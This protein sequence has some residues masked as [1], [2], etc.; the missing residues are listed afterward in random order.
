MADDDLEG[1][2]GY[3]HITAISLKGGQAAN[4]DP[5][6]TAGRNPVWYSID[7]QLPYLVSSGNRD[8]NAAA[9]DG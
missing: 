9:L 8:S 3:F 2:G 7:I 6:W 1:I 4:G 5:G